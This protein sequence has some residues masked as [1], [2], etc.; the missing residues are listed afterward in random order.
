MRLALCAAPVVL[1][2][3]PFVSA[4]FRIL[5]VCL[6]GGASAV[7]SYTLSSVIAQPT[8]CTKQLAGAMEC[9][10]GYLCVEAGD[11]GKAGD[12]NHDGRVDGID[13][14][15]LLADWGTANPRSDLDHDGVVNGFDLGVLLADG[16]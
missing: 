14:A 9:E 13:L 6:P 10:S 4:D 3:T 16:G 2:L 8:S 7:G 11:L 5:T 15:Y 12:I 1:L